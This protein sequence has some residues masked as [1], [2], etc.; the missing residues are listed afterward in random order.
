MLHDSIY[1]F[2]NLL[3]TD[4][5]YFCRINKTVLTSLNNPLLI[6]KHHTQEQ[7]KK[8][9]NI[10]FPL[11][12]YRIN[13]CLLIHL[14]ISLL[15][16]QSNSSAS[17]PSRYLLLIYKILSIVY[18]PRYFVFFCIRVWLILMFGDSSTPP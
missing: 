6:S 8:S 5:F 2:I 16:N 15:I 13:S 7:S 4:F 14:F 17:F 9:M 1:P 12:I 11:S 3:N 10:T 18:T